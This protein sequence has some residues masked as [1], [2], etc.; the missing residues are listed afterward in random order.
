M[1]DL[2]EAFTIFL[3]YSDDY[4]PLNCEHDELYVDVDPEIV[5]EDDKKR[6]YELSFEPSSEYPEGFTSF[7]FGSC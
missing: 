7:R 4:A 2:I 1:K 6:L 3:K 5:S